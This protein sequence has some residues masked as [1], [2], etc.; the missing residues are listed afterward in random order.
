MNKKHGT[1]AICF[2]AKDATTKAWYRE[3]N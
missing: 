2:E 3:M 1:M